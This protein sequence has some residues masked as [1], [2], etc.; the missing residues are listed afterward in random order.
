M[1][2]GQEPDVAILVGAQGDAVAPQPAPEP[3]VGPGRHR[4]QPRVLPGTR[5]QDRRQTGVAH[6]TA[7]L[8]CWPGC[9]P[10]G[11]HRGVVEHQIAEVVD[12]VVA[13]LHRGEGGLAVGGLGDGH[14][15][16]GEAPIGVVGALAPLRSSLIARRGRGGSGGVG[17]QGGHRG[18][19]QDEVAEV[20]G[21]VVA[22]L[23]RGEGGL[24]VGGL[25]DG[26]RAV[27]EAEQTSAPRPVR[28]RLCSNSR[29]S[30]H[31][32]HPH[33]QADSHDCHGSVQP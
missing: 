4:N 9:G 32:R 26:H 12:G 2:A 16:A 7:R 24:A 17:P 29:R 15:L 11:G 19:V 6:I 14:G 23:D 31:R 27:G 22:P 21:G 20:V 3:P 30:R 18:V 25:G 10:Q 8:G 5:P 28:H 33:H 1:L 13:P